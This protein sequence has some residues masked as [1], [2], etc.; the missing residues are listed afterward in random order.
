MQLSS[1]FCV[2]VISPQVT[3]L[4]LQP[5]ARL[6][7]VFTVLFIPVTHLFRSSQCSL[8]VEVVF[9]LSQQEFVGLE[10]KNLFLN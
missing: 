1:R 5:T 3:M 2:E 6:S 9:R 7:R 4:P 8:T 10:W